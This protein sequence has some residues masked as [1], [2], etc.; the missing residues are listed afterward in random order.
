MLSCVVRSP[1]S[2]AVMLNV[3]YETID[4]MT[5]AVDEM[6]KVVDEMTKSVQIRG[7]SSVRQDGMGQLVSDDVCSVMPKIRKIRESL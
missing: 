5:K 3:V 6:T 1:Q 2:T 4:G 7:R